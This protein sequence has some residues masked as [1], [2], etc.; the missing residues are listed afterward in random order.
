MKRW[1]RMI[2]RTCRCSW[3]VCLRMAYRKS[4]PRTGRAPQAV[5]VRHPGWRLSLEPA[6]HRSAEYRPDRPPGWS[7]SRLSCWSVSRPAAVRPRRRQGRR[8]SAGP[9]SAGEITAAAASSLPRPARRRRDPGGVDPCGQPSPCR[10]LESTAA[11]GE[12]GVSGER[13]GLRGTCQPNGPRGGARHGGGRAAWAAAAYA[14]RWA[15]IFSI[16]TGS[17]MHAMMRIAPTSH[18]SHWGQ[19][20]TF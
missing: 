18:S 8:R 11:R 13:A 19:R 14:S 1:L 20:Y 16:T 2:R 4:L 17:S 10:G 12:T 15:R 5:V 6:D 9:A 7:L 3:S